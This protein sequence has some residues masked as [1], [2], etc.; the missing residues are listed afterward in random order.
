[1]NEQ[2]PSLTGDDLVSS[3]AVEA[4]SESTT[5]STE[6]STRSTETTTTSEST[7]THVAGATS[8]GSG[9]VTG[10]FLAVL[11]RGRVSERTTE[12]EREREDAPRG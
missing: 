1:M 8:D 6:A 12:V 2:M 7:G 4:S 3:S 10:V 11:R 5:S 9:A